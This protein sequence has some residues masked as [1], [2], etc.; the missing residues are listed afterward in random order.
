MTSNVNDMCRIDTVFGFV[1]F[2]RLVGTIYEN[3]H[4]L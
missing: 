4:I 1:I 2:L 3:V